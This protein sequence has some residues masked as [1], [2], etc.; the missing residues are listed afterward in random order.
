MQKKYLLP[1]LLCFAVSVQMHAQRLMGVATGNYLP[2]KTTY[3]NPALITDSRLKW[4]VDLFSL[5]T[6]LD[7]NYG[8]LNPKGVLDQL[9]SG[10]EITLDNALTK[11]NTAFVQANLPI[12]DAHLLDVYLNI[13]EKHSLALTSRVR[14]FSQLRDYDRAMFDAL[15]LN[16]GEDFSINAQKFNQNASAW[17]DIGLTYATT[18]FENSRHAIYGGL[19]LRYLNGI[20][21]GGYSSNKLQGSFYNAQ[22]SVQVDNLDMH[23]AS[24]INS[25]DVD[26]TYENTSDIFKS[27]FSG[28]TGGF[29]ADL[30]FVYEFRPDAAKKVYEM[31][32]NAS[33]RDPTKNLYK[34]RISAAITDLGT[35]NYKDANRMTIKGSGSINTN[36]FS[37]YAGDYDSL[38]WYMKSRGFTIDSG[39]EA[40]KVSMPTAIVLGAD[41]HITKGFYVNGTLIAGLKPPHYANYSTYTHSQFTFTPRWENRVVTVGLPITYNMTTSNM[42]MGLGLRILP[43]YIGSDDLLGLLGDGLGKGANFYFG[44]HVPM[45]KRRLKDS[46][47]DKVSNKLDKCP[48]EQGEWAYMGCKP[49]DRDKDG[50]IDSLDK[51]PDIAGVSTAQGCPDADLDGIADGEDLCVNEAGTVATKG[52]PDRDG[53]GIADKDD[54]CPD[55][56]GEARFQ[57]CMDTDGDGL[58]DWEDK[59][60]EKAGSVANQGCPDSDNDGILDHLDRCPTVAGTVANHGCPEIRADVKKRLAFAAT[61]IQFETGKAIIKPVSYKLLDEIVAILNEYRDYNMRIDGHTDD[62]GKD[63]MNMDLSK[64]R[65]ASVKEYFVSKGISS[66]RLETN[67]YGESKPKASNKTAKGRAQNRRVEMDLYLAE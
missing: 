57:G 32:G 2:T 17:T 30:G 47:F 29:G 3:L 55:V 36:N 40:T 52:C 8:T 26:F 23:V 63:D 48:K 27:I 39:K 35:I 37:N 33:R 60:P 38:K 34:L 59:C 12:L 49:T 4:S 66:D 58:G 64:A 44:L 18:I 53:D 9:K 20:R 31:D 41:Y 28:K 1:I 61:A 13:K 22:D 16:P 15:Y 54:K 10:N 45:A 67:G 62:V 65:A 50:I 42:K 24:N 43:L 19:S 6:L 14:V 51:C 21:F 5:N 56:A 7:Q 11:G 25:N 46:D